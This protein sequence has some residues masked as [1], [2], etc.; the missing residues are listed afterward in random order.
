MVLQ[1][2]IY[3]NPNQLITLITATAAAIAEG[4][5]AS[6]LAVIATILTQLADTLETIALQKERFEQ[7]ES[8][9]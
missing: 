9:Q 4:R 6:E 1:G 7:N 8:D 5:T 2:G 3:M